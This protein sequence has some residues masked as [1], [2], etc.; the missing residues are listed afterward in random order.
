MVCET[1]TVESS[2]VGFSGVL[3]LVLMEY[4]LRAISI[5]HYIISNQR[6]NPCFNGIWSA[7]VKSV[8]IC[9]WALYDQKDR[10]NRKFWG[11]T[12]TSECKYTKVFRIDCTTCHLYLTIFGFSGI[13]HRW[14]CS[15]QGVT[16][17]SLSGEC[18]TLAGSLILKGTLV[19]RGLRHFV[20]RHAGYLC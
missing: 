15:C 18:D 12:C 1:L 16:R 6:L 19:S 13:F 11:K 10:R 4:G 14:L 5:I 20:P 7:R 17:L 8:K 9:V 3:I 2:S